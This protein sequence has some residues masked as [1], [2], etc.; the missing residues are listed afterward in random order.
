MSSRTKMVADRRLDD[1]DSI[2]SRDRDF[3]LCHRVQISPK[4][5]LPDSYQM[6]TVSL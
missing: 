6:G 4:V 3:L 1:Q 2:L 5:H